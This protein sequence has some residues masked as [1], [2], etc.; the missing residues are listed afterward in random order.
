MN[1]EYIFDD[2]IEEL[3]VRT[4][5]LNNVLSEFSEILSKMMLT[6]SIDDFST[7]IDSKFDKDLSEIS[8]KISKCKNWI[9]KYNSDLVIL[10][11]GIKTGTT[12]DIIE[13]N[14]AKNIIDGDFR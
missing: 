5:N 4:N 3:P 8:E 12:N 6:S 13:Y 11:S 9:E 2:V 10:N 1:E 14:Q 7:L